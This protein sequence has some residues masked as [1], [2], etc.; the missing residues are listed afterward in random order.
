MTLERDLS[1]YVSDTEGDVYAITGLPEE[2][3]AVVFA[4]VS[5]SP[6]LAR[7]CSRS[8]KSAPSGSTRSGSCTTATP[9]WPSMR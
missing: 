7:I 2:I 3:L 4:Y 5:R 1:R 8:P 9:R 6:K